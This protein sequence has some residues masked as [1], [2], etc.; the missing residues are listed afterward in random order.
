MR[1]T[2]LTLIALCLLGLVGCTTTESPKVESRNLHSQG[3]ASFY[4]KGHERFQGT[5]SGEKFNPEASTVA[6]KTLPFGTKLKIVN[7]RNNKNVVV[8]VNDRGPYVKNR[9]VDVSYGVAKKLDFDRS[10]LTHVKMYI[11]D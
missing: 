10:G 3:I 4:G 9:I 1:S 5:A 11:V 8:R 6:H 2:K 7:T